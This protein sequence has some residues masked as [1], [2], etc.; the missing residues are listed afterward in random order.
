MIENEHCWV[1]QII[2]S[3]SATC[4]EVVWVCYHCGKPRDSIEEAVNVRVTGAA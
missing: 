1:M 3:F 2:K 4:H